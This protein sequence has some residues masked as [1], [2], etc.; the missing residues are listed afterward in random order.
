M[1][2]IRWPSYNPKIPQTSPKTLWRPQFVYKDKEFSKGI[3]G[4]DDLTLAIQ[5]ALDN[6]NSI[7][8][9]GML[10]EEQQCH[11]LHTCPYGWIPAIMKSISEIKY[12]RYTLK[13]HQTGPTNAHHVVRLACQLSLPMTSPEMTENDMKLHIKEAKRTLWQLLGNPKWRAKWLENLASAQAS[14]SQ[15]DPAKC[16]CHLQ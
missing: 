11:K 12:W 13:Q 8:E 3:Q 9:Q 16:L 14:I 6:I 5:Y 2:Q 10:R 1:T 7:Q 15:M 4:P